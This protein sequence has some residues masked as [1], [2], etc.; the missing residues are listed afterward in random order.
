MRKN[1]K[2]YANWLHDDELQAKI[3]DI[4]FVSKEI[5]YHQ[6]CRVSYQNLAI[7]SK[8]RK[9]NADKTA[10]HD[11]DEWNTWHIARE[12]HKKSLEALICYIDDTILGKKEVHSL[13]H[14]NN[15]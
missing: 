2:T 13:V 7:K 10:S 4:D 9:D 5:H 1:V 14:I 12:V 3:A 11:G 15:H 6:I 8:K